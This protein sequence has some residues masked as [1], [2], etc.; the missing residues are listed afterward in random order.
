MTLPKASIANSASF[1]ISGTPYVYSATAT[2]TIDF[3][4]VT[5]AITIQ[6]TGV[7]NKISFDGGTN[8][9]TLIQNKIYKLK[10][11]CK[12]LKITWAAGTV[13]IVAE[14]TSVEAWQ[15]TTIVQGNYVTIYGCTDPLASNTNSDP[16]V[17]H[18]PDL[19]QYASPY[20][21][22]YHF[23]DNLDEEGG[24]VTQDGGNRVTQYVD[25]DNYDP[26]TFGRAA[27]FAISADNV[28]FSEPGIGTG[29]FTIECWIKPS[30]QFYTTIVSA[31]NDTNTLGNGS[32]RLYVHTGAKLL[33]DIKEGGVTQSLIGSTAKSL[34]TWRHIAVVRDTTAEQFRLYEDGD[35]TDTLDISVTGNFDMDFDGVD[36]VIGHY[37]GNSYSG[38]YRYEGY[39]DEFLISKDVRYT[40]TGAGAYTVPTVPYT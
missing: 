37:F 25:N 19:C 1:Q 7:G 9:L 11:K 27:R 34:N 21:V 28:T 33:F 29:D 20:T 23:E 8:Q 14:L 12:Q 36:W 13:D 32:F 24:E 4:Y 10:V 35:C 22:L 30:T 39:M 40:G 26:S 38:S 15:A 17:I 31:P 2:K 18:N 5:R 16:G 6:S 3:K